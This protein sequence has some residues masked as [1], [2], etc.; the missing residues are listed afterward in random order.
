M[1]PYLAVFAMMIGRYLRAAWLVILTRPYLCLSRSN[2]N[3]DICV[4][5]LKNFR[6]NKLHKISR[7]LVSLT[8]ALAEIVEFKHVETLRFKLSNTGLARYHTVKGH[9]HD[10]WHEYVLAFRKVV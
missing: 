9:S 6:N 10:L 5:V 3:R 7:D 2:N 1:N 8:I 4:I